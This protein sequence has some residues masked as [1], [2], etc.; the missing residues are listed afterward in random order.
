MKLILLGAPAAG[1]GTVSKQLER[2]YH[3][4]PFSTGAELRQQ[5]AAGTELGRKAKNYMDQ[6]HLVPDEMIL[7]IVLSKLRGWDNYILDGFP[8]N[9]VQAEAIDEITFN[10][11]LYLQINEEIA[12][13]RISGRRICSVC[14]AEY[15][16]KFVPPKEA[17]ICDKCHGTLIQRGDDTP[18]K[19]RER[20]DVFIKSTRPLIDYYQRKG[21]LKI[22]DATLSP[23]EV[24]AQVKSI[25]DQLK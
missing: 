5:V 22:V 6:G 18:E 4:T 3:L 15:H 7:D 9:R 13:E 8:R 16:T 14:T 23:L 19:A 11:V 24:Y 17:E 20:Y 25:V 12:V 2:D 1:K 21:L 10:R